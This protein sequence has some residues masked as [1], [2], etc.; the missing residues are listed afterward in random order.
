[1]GNHAFGSALSLIR[2][3][4]HQANLLFNTAK[5][6]FFFIPCKLFAQLFCNFFVF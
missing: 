6:V 2:L 4:S 5:L 1:M 3:S